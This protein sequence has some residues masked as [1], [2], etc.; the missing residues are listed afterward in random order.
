VLF[1]CGLTSVDM[2]TGTQSRSRDVSGKGYVILG[3]GVEV[4]C[5]GG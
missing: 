2:A 3:S 1:R 4:W 5:E